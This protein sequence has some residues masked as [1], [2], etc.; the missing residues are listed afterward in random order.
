MDILG[1]YQ[2]LTEQ[3]FWNVEVLGNI[4]GGY[5]LAATAFLAFLVVF[6]LFQMVIIAHLKKLA[7]KTETDIDDTL[8]KIVQSLRPPFYSFLALY[9][10]LQFLTLNEM[11]GR[12]IEVFLIIWVVYQA[13]HALQILFEYIFAKTLKARGQDSGAESALGLLSNIVKWVL[14]SVGLLMIL[15]N[16]GVNVTSLVAGLGIGGLA[17]ALA[18]QNILSDL[19]SSFSIIFDKPFKVGDFITVGGTSGTVE[20]IGIKTTRLKS[21]RGEEIVMSNNQLTSAEVLNFGKLEE[22][23]NI[24]SLGATYETPTEKLKKIPDMVKGIIE[25]H[26]GVRFDRAHFKTFADSALV[27]EIVY[28][29]ETDAY[30]EHMDRQQAINFAIREAFEREGIDMAYPTQTLHVVK[31]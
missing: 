24:I 6:K 27:F 9:F 13:I 10:A 25:S 30:A 16:L 29:A 28:Y 26:E 22:R 21:P 15:S 14:W 31:S 5:I 19:F 20:R 8:I 11:L 17:F 2:Q 12:V 18:A 23:R 1:M 4:V 7:L 3:A